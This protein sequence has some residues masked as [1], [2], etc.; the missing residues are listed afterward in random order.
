MDLRRDNGQVEPIEFTY[1]A[2]WQALAWDYC[3]LWC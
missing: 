3:S 1:C 2:V